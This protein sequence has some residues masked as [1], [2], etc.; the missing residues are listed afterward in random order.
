MIDNNTPTVKSE[1]EVVKPKAVKS[2][3]NK[4]HG[5][6][7]IITFSENRKDTLR[8][9]SASSKVVKST[10]SA[11]TKN[12]KKSDNLKQQSLLDMLKQ[13]KKRI[14]T[15]VPTKPVEDKIQQNENANQVAKTSKV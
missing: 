3:T 4:L 5:L 14:Q 10:N 6:N 7:Q 8:S 13:R 9:A 1:P 2:K 11:F 15:N 12:E